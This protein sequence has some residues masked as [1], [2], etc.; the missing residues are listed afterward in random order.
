MRNTILILIILLAGFVS[1]IP[2]E[3]ISLNQYVTDQAQVLTDQEEKEISNTL[4]QVMSSG[5]A[6][7]A[8]V[9]VDNLEGEAIE[10]YAL[11]IVQDKLGNENNNGLLLLISIEERKYRFE[12]GRGLEAEIPDI[13]LGIIGREILEPAFKQEK[14]GEGIIEA[15]KVI[16]E[17]LEGKPYETK[18]S[19]ENYYSTIIWLMIFLI[20]FI[21]PL[22]RA[23]QQ[24]PKK[25]TLKHSNQDLFTAAMIGGM[26]GRGGGGF[27]GSGGFGGGGF[28]GGGAGGSW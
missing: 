10:N 2:S 27:G 3:Q 4:E 25:G 12:T 6:E 20:F 28:G 16:N 26:I 19:N 14:Y 17:Q 22:I 13:T 24:P 1:A 23:K 8:I 7:F 11:S 15:I 5:K 21:I 9:L 18:N